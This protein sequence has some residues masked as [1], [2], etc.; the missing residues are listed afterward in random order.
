MASRPA[1]RTQSSGSRASGI[2]IEA[3]LRRRRAGLHHEDLLFDGIVELSRQAGALLLPCS[4]TD[5]LFV[6]GAC[7][8]GAPARVLEHVEK[9]VSKPWKA[10]GRERQIEEQR[11][12][13]HRR[14]RERERQMI[15]PHPGPLRQ[16]NRPH[17]EVRQ[18]EQVQAPSPVEG[19][20]GP[21]E[22]GGAEAT[23]ND[24][25]RRDENERCPSIRDGREIHLL[26]GRKRPSVASAAPREQPE[27]AGDR[28]PAVDAEDQPGI[29][30][31][32]CAPVRHVRSVGW[33]CL[34]GIP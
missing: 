4:L 6:E 15:A 18:R 2:C 23:A 10:M 20:S 17:H 33:F 22:A 27:A 8:T 32:R 26:E 13:H 21:R 16:Q 11:A 29:D 31:I 25:N 30:R 24:D 9:P 1:V 14:Q 5:L 34:P 12:R 28:D 7:P 19:V 3:R